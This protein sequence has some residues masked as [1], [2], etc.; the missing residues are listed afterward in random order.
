MPRRQDQDTFFETPPEWVDRTI[1]AYAAPSDPATK[2]AAPN[3]VMT[4][5]P[6]RPSDSLRAHTD[7]QLLELGRHLKDFDLLESSD[8]SLGGSPAVLLRYTWMSHFGRLE[9]TVTVVD[10]P[11]EKGRVAT[12]FTTTC[13]F[14]D[15]PKLKA[16]FA[17]LLRSVRFDQP[18]PGGSI[19]P[20]PSRPPTAND[21]VPFVPMPGQRGDR[22]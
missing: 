11:A 17:D 10:R 4:R 7:R 21:V 18:P 9:Q 20:M 8:T 6:I 3:F 5:E 19:P 14:E 22:R 16:L 1:V 15:A 2:E 13:K 12:S